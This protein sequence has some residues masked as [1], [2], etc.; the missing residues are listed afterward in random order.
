MLVYHPIDIGIP[1]T[2]RCSDLLVFDWQKSAADFSIHGDEEHVLR[3]LFKGAV[4][5]R[6]LDETWLSTESDPATWVGLVPH[7]FAYRVEGAVFAQT[8]SPLLAEMVDRPLIHYQFVTGSG[9]LDALTTWDA[10]FSLVART[11]AGHQAAP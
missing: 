4:I 3:V 9:C 8:Q 11:S 10:E 5:A 1:I 7:H 2:G 6:L